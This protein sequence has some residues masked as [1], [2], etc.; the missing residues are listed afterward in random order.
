MSENYSNPQ[1]PESKQSKKITFGSVFSFISSILLF[2]L[3][4]LFLITPSIYFSGIIGIIFILVSFYIFPPVNSIIVKNTGFKLNGFTNFFLVIFIIIVN[5]IIAAINPSKQ[6]TILASNDSKSLVFSS[7]ATKSIYISSSQKATNSSSKS[8]SQKELSSSSISLQQ[9]SEVS[10]DPELLKKAEKD[11]FEYFRL[12][13]KLKDGVEVKITKQN[14]TIINNLNENITVADLNTYAKSEIY[15]YAEDGESNF[16]ISKKD[17]YRV[18]YAD[19]FNDKMEYLNTNFKN[20]GLLFKLTTKTFMDSVDQLD[21]CKNPT[22]PE[23]KYI[24]KNHDILCNIYV[25]FAK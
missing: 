10:I 20:D 2:L 9:N 16:G 1:N 8:S 24:L 13:D 25:N 18:N 17:Y 3:G 7:S 14:A 21:L 15:K 22:K 19:F 5:F 6:D 12:M 4:L 11:K 23:N